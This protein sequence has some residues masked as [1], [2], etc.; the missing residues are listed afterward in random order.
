MQQL[1]SEHE[2]EGIAV[3][4]T[5]LIYFNSDLMPR[6]EECSPSPVYIEYLLVCLYLLKP[7][8]CHQAAVL[9][10]PKGSRAGQQQMTFLSRP[11]CGGPKPALIGTAGRLGR[12]AAACKASD[13]SA[14]LSRYLHFF[15]ISLKAELPPAHGK[16]IHLLSIVTC[17]SNE[18]NCIKIGMLF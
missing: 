1:S 6:L 4:Y 14:Q 13:P 18:S 7:L 8:R 16:T 12:A 17:S 2:V 10:G 5:A 11:C 3:L 9:E 15:Y